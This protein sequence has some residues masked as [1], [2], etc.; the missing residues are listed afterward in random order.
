MGKQTSN[1]GD[2]VTR[3]V[4][5]TFTATGRSGNATAGLQAGPSG[6]LPPVFKGPFNISLWGTFVATVRVARSFDGGTT[7]LPVAKNVDGDEASYDEP[8]SLSVF[9]AE[10]NVLYSVECTAFTSGTVNYRIAQ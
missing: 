10:H 7:W 3:V 8:V 6:S 2:I 9:E 4:S 5:G 1:A